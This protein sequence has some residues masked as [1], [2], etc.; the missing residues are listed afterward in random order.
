MGIRLSAPAIWGVIAHR[1]GGPTRCPAARYA[2]GLA[3]F[4]ADTAWVRQHNSPNLKQKKKKRLALL[5]R[6]QMH[7]VYWESHLAAAAPPMMRRK[8]VAP[9]CIR[10]ASITASSPAARIVRDLK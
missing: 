2:T 6:R 7:A 1:V 8:C 9:S 3:V 4:V 10:H 5:N